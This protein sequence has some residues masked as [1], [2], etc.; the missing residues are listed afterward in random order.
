LGRLR[1]WIGIIVI[2]GM[3][4]SGVLG[5]A[6]RRAPD[7][8][9]RLN[10]I[11]KPYRFSIL[12]WELSQILGKPQPLTQHGESSAANGDD[13]ELVLE[14]F[15]LVHQTR[16]VQRGINAIAAGNRQGDLAAELAELERLQ[17]RK[18]AL[19]NTVR[20]IIG[21]Q[22]RETLNRQG[23]FNPA[24]RY[25]QVKIHF[26]PINFRLD[27][28][29]NVLI[30]SPRDRIESIRE[31][32]LIQDLDVDQFEDIEARVSALGVSALVTELGGFG[33]T[34]PT[35]VADDVSLPWTIATATEEWLH[36]YLA[37]TPLGFMYLLDTIGVARNYEI[38]TMNETLAGMVSGE[39]AA[40]V[41]ATYY[42]HYETPRPQGG[43]GD[44]GFDFNRA[45]R[46]LRLAVDELLA[47]GE[48]ERAEELMEE[49]RQYLA[50][51]GYYI[52]KL[53]QA[54]F[55]F[56]GTYAD[57]PTSVSPIGV[58]MKELREQSA[59]LREFLN[60]AAAMT[61]RQDL[62]DSLKAPPDEEELFVRWLHEWVDL[63]CSAGG[64]VN[65]PRKAAWV[66]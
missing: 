42:P 7:F 16:M 20:R 57:E 12:R 10:A 41:L 62:T 14:Y 21:R 33:G 53:N 27:Q 63:F 46:E 58:E 34:Y 35:F 52:R 26:P 47:N 65:Q 15:S 1:R 54:Y 5:T 43:T 36:Q 50:S 61:S 2:A 38:A 24:D 29:P 13:I 19:R 40:L 23:I 8:D 22:I 4:L 9:D 6:C 44:A 28:P 56:Y 32:M 51:K 66:E 18:G 37:F 3:L 17:A 59:S 39:I 25:I 60:T 30:I 64:N 55:A 49:R 48:V 31:I 45:M 11:I